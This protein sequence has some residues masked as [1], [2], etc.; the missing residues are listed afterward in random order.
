V[1]PRNGPAV[2]QRSLPRRN[3]A[4]CTWSRRSTESAFIVSRLLVIGLVALATGTA[5]LTAGLA[6]DPNSAVGNAP[7][8]HVAADEGRP[9]PDEAQASASRQRP[10]RFR[11]DAAI[12]RRVVVAVP[13][14]AEVTE[15][16]GS[17]AGRDPGRTDSSYAVTVVV[18]DDH[19]VMD[20]GS[21][22]DPR[23]YLKGAA[24]RALRLP[25][26]DTADYPRSPQEDVLPAPLRV[27]GNQA[28]AG[29][30]HAIVAAHTASG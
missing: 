16:A 8:A 19:R 2:E 11:R 3:D 25:F 12:P 13:P 5:M 10:E 20:A 22:S 17:Y 9:M 29:A 1:A 21:P 6:I 15:P 30:Y 18:R 28:A 14:A 23:V 24:A 4:V 26:V 7:A 27:T